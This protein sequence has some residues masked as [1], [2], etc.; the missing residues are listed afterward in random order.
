[1][2]LKTYL[3]GFFALLSL[4]LLLGGTTSHG[5]RLATAHAQTPIPEATPN[6]PGYQDAP[7]RQMNLPRAW[8]KAL[9]MEASLPT[10]TGLN[11]PAILVLDGAMDCNNRDIKDVC[12]PELNRDFTTDNNYRDGVYDHGTAVASKIAGGWNNAFQAT[13]ILPSNRLL[14]IGG[15]VISSATNTGRSDWIRAGMDY[16]VYLKRELGIN[17]IGINLS[18]AARGADDSQAETLKRYEAL[19][20]NRIVLGLAIAPSS[21]PAS[22]DGT[23]LAFLSLIPKYPNVFAVAPLRS[24]GQ[25]LAPTYP[26]GRRIVG[27]AAPGENINQAVAGI[28]RPEVT[29]TGSGSSVAVPET[30]GV[31]ALVSIW[32]QMDPVL[33]LYVVKATSKQT[34]GTDGKIGWGLPDAFAALITDFA[35]PTAG[36]SLMTVAGSPLAAAADN[37]TLQSSPIPISNPHTLAADGCGRVMFLSPSIDVLGA[38]NLVLELKDL[39][40]TVFNVPIEHMSAVPSHPELAQLTVRIPDGVTAGDYWA[41]LVNGTARSNAVIL[42]LQ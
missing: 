31:V 15:K 12:V 42:S 41:A 5:L 19:L 30:L 6:D 21:Q 8:A 20:S 10:L 28:D 36:L 13:P 18:S 27:F 25:T 40:G 11:R 14:L 39:N 1:M 26:W 16:A 17:V 4:F 37:I 23:N 38:N 7:A 9:S 24:D 35:A 34:S 22:L 3:R 32:R 29:A 2:N 33:A